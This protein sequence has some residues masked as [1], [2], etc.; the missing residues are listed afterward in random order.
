MGSR[1][2]IAQHPM[3]VRHHLE[4]TPGKAT[5]DKRPPQMLQPKQNSPKLP[6]VDA[7]IRQTLNG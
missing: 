5:K 3:I 4:S 6:Q 1:L 7:M 2:L